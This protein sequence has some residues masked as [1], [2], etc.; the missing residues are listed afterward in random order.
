MGTVYNNKGYC[1][2]ELNRLD[3]A[4][5]FINKAI[6]MEPKRSYIWGSRGYLFY[7]KDDFTSC[8]ADMSRA[9]E[10]SSVTTN[11]SDPAFPYYFRGL[12]RI[13]LGQLKEGCA[14]LTRAK[15]MGKSEAHAAILENCK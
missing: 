13:K 15:E 3:D 12:A 4:L 5:P 9:I 1:L 7:L 2:I 8:I 11:S 6:E 14:D 10:L